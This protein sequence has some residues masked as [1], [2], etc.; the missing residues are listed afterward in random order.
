MTRTLIYETSPATDAPRLLLVSFHFPP[1]QTVGALRWARIA[2]WIAE[3]GWELDVITAAHGPL[4]TAG[5]AR[6]RALPAG[7]RIF[8]VPTPQTV[9]NRLHRAVTTIARTFTRRGRDDTPVP[10]WVRSDT[11]IPSSLPVEEI[12]LDLRDYRTLRRAYTVWILHAQDLAWS[13]AA[14]ALGLQL[15]QGAHYMSVV[16]C[17]PP[18]LT[19]EAGR[20]LAK[21]TGRP[22][23]MDLR[24]PWSIER[25]LPEAYAS[26]LFFS[27][28]RRYERRTVAEADLVVTNTH[29]LSDAM[30]KRYPPANV[31]TVMNGF[32]NEPL[33]SSGE[34]SCFVVAYAGGIYVDRDPRPLFRAVHQ[35]VKQL[36]LTP[37]EFRVEMI[38]QVGSF[39]GVPLEV[40]AREEGVERH[41]RV[42][43]WRPREQVLQFLAQASVVVC[44]PQDNPYA[45]PSK[46]FEYMRFDAWL[47]VLAESGSPVH[48]LLHDT[49]ADIVSPRF[50]REIAEALQRRYRQFRAG[51]RARPIATDRRFSQEV[52]VKPLLSAIASR[53]GGVTGAAANDEP[54]AI[55]PLEAAVHA[56]R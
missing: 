18:H 25:R 55:A 2:P 19:H 37:D 50:D 13:R 48:E 7:T 5:R 3:R 15:A 24:D 4:D 39:G 53:Y 17:G 54:C 10:D 35:V 29:A 40:I 9:V 12:R 14:A 38:G 27:L 44:L 45:I 36:R 46:V 56:D 34:R 33:P 49:D 1:A 26:P 16:T 43:P 23:I 21:R 47:L 41:V 8:G 6:L 42:L 28:S 51:G 32:D 22:F 31:L 30:Q 11:P 52:Q 20:L